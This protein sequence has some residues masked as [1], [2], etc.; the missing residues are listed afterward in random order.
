MATQEYSGGTLLASAGQSLVSLGLITRGKVHGTFPGGDIS[1]SKGDVVGL[2]DIAFDSHFLTYQAIEDTSVIVLPLKDMKSIYDLMW[3]NA[4]VAKTLF[5]SMVSQTVT[6]LSQYLRS[7]EE[8]EIMHTQLL[9]WYNSYRQISLRNN[10]IS[11]SLAQF[12][13]FSELTLEEDI[14]GWLGG[15]YESF[16]N[17][18]SEL[19]QSM[20][21]NADFMCG[22]LIHASKDLHGILS[23]IGAINDYY[24]DKL[25]IVMQDNGIDLFDFCTGL[26]FR[27]VPGSDDFEQLS[28]DIENMIDYVKKHPGVDPDTLYERVTAYQERRSGLIATNSVNNDSADDTQGSSLSELNNS[29]DIILE[30]SGVAEAVGNV[31]RTLVSKY[32]R[33]PDRNS[34]DNEAR[35]L[36]EELTKLFY[37]IYVAVLKK[38]FKEKNLLPAVKMFLD[39]GYVDEEL[40][41]KENAAYLY[42]ISKSFIGNPDKGI[43][44]ASEWLKAVY[45]C[46]KEPSRNEFDT[47]YISHLHELK[48]AGKITAADEQALTENGDARLKYE[49]ENMFPLVNKITFGRITTFTPVFSEHNVLKPLQSS[50]VSADILVE[51]L[52]KIKAIDYSAF[53]RDNIYT[54]EQIGI[55][56]EYIAVEVMPDIILT[57]NIGSRGI[58]WQEIE[59]RKRTTPARFAISAFHLEDIRI[60]LTH[61]V[62]EFRWEMC[63][64][65]QGGRWNDVTDKSL[66]SEYFDYVQFYKKNNELSQEAKEKIKQNLIKSKNSFKEMFVR[67]YLLWVLFEGTGSPRLNKVSRAIFCTYCP[68][69]AELRKKIMINPL[70]K[71]LLERYE[72]KNRAKIHRFDNIITKLT[73]AK[74]PIPQEILDHRAFLAGTVET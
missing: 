26:L 19:V 41:G 13:S 44:T 36:R 18:A 72:T 17:F 3:S 63:K 57:P 52:K 65:I 39:F 37:E 14:D 42:N 16:D 11:R 32:K 50:L 8:C 27:L 10:I 49:L 15:F 2:I 9:E 22:F 7:K 28:A 48:L 1:L 31:F 67:D 46:K 70:Y 29:L 33:M 21:E 47:D 25:S 56:K 6:L 64:R 38:S 23:V 68:F 71:E 45:C 54:N 5:K 51:G 53:Y 59:G 66:T 58:M 62:G 60:T 69:P 40:A 24:V 34:S 4:D 73:T 20:V 30:Y 43:Y 61:L 12:D 74:I 55:S 35:K